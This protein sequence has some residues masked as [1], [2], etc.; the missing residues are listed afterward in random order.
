MLDKLSRDERLLLLRFVC[1]FAWAD[2]DIKPK[3][4]RFVRDLVARL[5]LDSSEAKLVQGWLEVPPEV[6]AIDPMQI[7]RAHRE[8]FLSAVR[9]MMSVDGEIQPEE[10]ES[11]LLLEQLTR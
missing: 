11:L 7:P 4:R 1:S 8:I 5:G 10:G 9:A 6:E 2:F 3:E